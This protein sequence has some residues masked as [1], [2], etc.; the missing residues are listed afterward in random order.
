MDPVL[1]HDAEPLAR[2]EAWL[3]GR[4]GVVVLTGAGCSTASGLPG[5]RDAA[6]RWT[7]AEPIQYQQFVGDQAARRQY[8]A[9]GLTGYTRIAKALPNA[10]HEALAAL[11]SCGVID[12]L[13]TQN[14]DGL[15][16]A[17]GSK[18]VLELHG[19]LHEVVCLGCRNRYPRRAVQNELES[20]NPG[21]PRSNAELKPDGDASLG[22]A[23]YDGFRLTACR[24]CQGVLK[25]DVV[26]FGEAV[27]R[28]RAAAALAMVRGAK[29]L[30]VIGSS[31][32]VLSSFRLVREAHARAAGLAAI[33]LG[34]TRADDWFEL[35]LEAPCELVLRELSR[36]LT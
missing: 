19:S 1:A 4:S 7:G 12:A 27:P 11:E 10:A 20:L 13:I 15:H 18:R 14:V 2:L 28:E 8:W 5:Y 6:G 25:P 23:D 32:M 9:R 34:Q 3:R 31:L 33:N 29:A 26:F 30:L 17:A 35:K 21:W 36:R 22:A 16:A 24:A